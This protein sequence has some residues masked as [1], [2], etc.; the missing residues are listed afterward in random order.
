MTLPLLICN[1][2]KLAARLA[3]DLVLMLGSELDIDKIF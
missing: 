1:V 2:S 3:V